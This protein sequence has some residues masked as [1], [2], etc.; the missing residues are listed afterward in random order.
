MNSFIICTF[1]L[2]IKNIVNVTELVTVRSFPRVYKLGP[3]FSQTK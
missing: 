2:Y 1:N 3:T